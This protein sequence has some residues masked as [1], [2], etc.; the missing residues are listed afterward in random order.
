MQYSPGRYYRGLV[1]TRCSWLH[2]SIGGWKV[3]R[4][5]P[6]GLL[7]EPPSIPTGYRQVKY[8]K[9]RI[10]SSPWWIHYQQLAHDLQSLTNRTTRLAENPIYYNTTLMPSNRDTSMPFQRLPS[11]LQKHKQEG[12]TSQWKARAHPKDKRCRITPL[13]RSHNK[14]FICR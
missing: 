3:D 13:I 9:L 11:L 1:R 4:P 14:T 6:N 2:P 8:C 5:S 10:A 7:R 12:Q